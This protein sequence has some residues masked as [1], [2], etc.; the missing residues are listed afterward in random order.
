MAAYDY[1][2]R[3]CDGVFEVRRA[4]G[5]DAGTVRCPQGHEDVA[6]VWSAVSVGGLATSGASSAV[7][8]AGG[9]CGGGCCG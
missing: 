4:I 3:E 2:C 8:A 6:R 9:C 5:S 1:R 7:P